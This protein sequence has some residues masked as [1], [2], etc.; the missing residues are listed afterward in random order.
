MVGKKS[1]N[2]VTQNDE[3]A[4]PSPSIL[5]SLRQLSVRGI[6]DLLKNRLIGLDVDRLRPLIRFTCVFMVS[7]GLLLEIPFYPV[8]ITILLCLGLGAL[9][10]KHPSGALSLCLTLSLPALVYQNPGTVLLS[11]LFISVLIIVCNENWVEGFLILSSVELALSPPLRLFTPIPMILGGLFVSSSCGAAVGVLSSIM[12]GFFALGTGSPILGFL[13][14]PWSSYQFLSPLKSPLTGFCP[15]SIVEVCS[16]YFSQ[17]S[18]FQ[19]VV[20]V[21]VV[22]VN[23]YVTETTLWVEAVLWGLA[24]YLAGKVSWWEKLYAWRLYSTALATFIGSLVVSVCYVYFAPLHAADYL[25]ALALVAIATFVGLA[26]GYVRLEALSSDLVRLGN[27]VT[28]LEKLLKKAKGLGMDVAREEQQ[29]ESIT[30]AVNSVDRLLKTGKVLRA[31]ETLD[32]GIS[33]SSDCEE[34]LKALVQAGES[35]PSWSSR[36]KTLLDGW[37]KAS[38]DMLSEVPSRWRSY[39]L[40]RYFDEHKDEALILRHDVLTAPKVRET[41]VP[42]PGVMEKPPPVSLKPA[43]TLDDRVYAYIID[44]EGTISISRA[45]E[46]LGISKDELNVCIERLKKEGRLVAA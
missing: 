13:V 26:A 46:D 23:S 5:E 1:P 11:F 39:V 6:V 28:E 25:Q 15:Y 27:K 37:G 38:V 41:P 24:G 21:N 35:W 36:V 10:S 12:I 42:P 2:R 34:S 30:S 8:Y 18:A 16:V 22:W 43:V 45:A 20:D 40:Q 44:H 7:A 31:K 14:V 19:S 3:D 32:S 4:G 17:P 29:L 33:I 9:A